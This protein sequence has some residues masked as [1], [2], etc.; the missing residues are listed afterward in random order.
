MRAVL[1]LTIALTLGACVQANDAADTV[2]RNTAKG[3]VNDVVAQKFPGV[4]AAPVTDCVIDNASRFEIF[5]IAKAGATGVTPATVE[6]VTAIASR[7]ET[8]QC[9][10]KNGL[11]LFL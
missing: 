11:G 9:I 1:I 5:D 6:T 4:N 2:A 3:V 8:V 7:P 10:S